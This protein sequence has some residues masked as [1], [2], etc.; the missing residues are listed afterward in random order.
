MFKEEIQDSLNTI[1]WFDNMRDKLIARYRFS[2]L[3]D[4]IT[5]L[6]NLNCCPIKVN[7]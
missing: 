3:S 7:G 1:G 4:I 5:F 2:Y 6:W